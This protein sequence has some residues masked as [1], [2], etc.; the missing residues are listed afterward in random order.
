MSRDGSGTYTLPAGNP[1]VNGTLIDPAWANNTLSDIGNELTNS[2]DKA[3]RTTP[4]A[5]LPMGGF[6]FTALAAGSVAGNS[7]RYEQ[8]LNNDLTTIS[9]AA[10]VDLA[11]TL[12]TSVSV[13]GTTTLTSFGT[14]A[15]AGVR[16]WVTFASALSLTHSATLLCPGAQNLSILA[17]ETI[18]VRSEGSNV[19]RVDDDP[20]QAFGVPDGTVGSPGLFF[21]SDIDN[22]IYRIGA[23]NW[24]LVAGGV[25]VVDLAAG[26]VTFPLSTVVAAA[27][28]VATPGTVGGTTPSASVSVT[29]GTVTGT[30]ITGSI[31]HATGNATGASDS[32]SI[33]LQT[34]TVDN[35][36]KSAGDISLIAGDATNA[37]GGNG[38]DI[39]LATGRGFSGG[40]ALTIRV[41]ERDSATTHNIA[42]IDS[43]HGVWAWQTSSRPPTIT[44]GAG[45]GATIAG[46]W[47]GFRVV[48]GTTPGATIVIAFS[49]E[50][51][52][53]VS[54]VSVANSTNITYVVSAAGAASGVTL[55]FSA[56]PTAGDIISVV[57]AFFS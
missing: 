1:V 23:N 14:G 27:F 24:G 18:G 5:N 21:A 53:G 3:G 35:A 47:Y 25:K 54:A 56:T 34:G 29:T 9:S 39:L 13:T 8:A 37:S 44:S 40:G 50:D 28:T 11:G 2:L 55:T 48:V 43:Y 52:S 46:T 31:T 16:K 19:W 17:G 4:T 12:A 33:L 10:T 22:G 45:A 51:T 15:A 7:V 57:T 30:T 36:T 32:G 20:A 49:L 6:K 26:T 38:G 41:G 42:K